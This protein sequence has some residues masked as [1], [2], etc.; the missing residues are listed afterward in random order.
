MK[1]KIIFV[2]KALWI[3]GIETALVNLLN[4]FN[5]KK[6][7]VTLLVL[8]AELDMLKQIHP[9]CRV[10]IADRD[11]TVSFQEKYRYSRLYHLTEEP[12]NPSRLHKMMM[13]TVPV[14]RWT[15]N[16]FYIRYI[17]KMMKGERFDTAVIYS[18]V[19]GETAVRAIR[20]DKYLMF[21]HHGA[22]RHVY[23]DRIAYKKCE[24]IIAVSQH[25]AIDLRSYIP[26]Y[27]YKI[28]AVNNLADIK[29]IR[30]KSKETIQQNFEGKKFNIVTCGRVS[31]EKGMDLAIDACYKLILRGYKN[32]RW[33]IIGD[34][35]VYN[36]IKDQ[37]HR[38]NLENYVYLVGM[39]ENPY[40]YIEKADLY[41]QPSRFEGYPMSILEA[42][43]L[44]KIVVATANNGAEEMLKKLNCGILSKIDSQ[45]LSEK[46][47]ELIENEQY[48]D[49]KR[50][51]ISAIDFEQSNME[52]LKQIEG[53]L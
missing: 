6:Y 50:H 33:W 21:Y 45:D 51:E 37:I 39:K 3:G 2:T 16:R 29:G 17:R 7:D 24:K 30:E 52:S 23:H 18:D 34:G 10:L 36:E 38:L 28:V 25:Q 4:N 47:G 1:K 53:F 8:K 19:A 48:Y 41:V 26:K 35:P 44:K 11:E 42:L 40:P 15:E 49:K 5:Y 27:A 20:A 32:I 46:I 12:E 22:M 13:W 31:K 43:I 14:I 9:K